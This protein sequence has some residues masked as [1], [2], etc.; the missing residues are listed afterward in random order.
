M[1]ATNLYYYR[2][3]TPWYIYPVRQARA[4]FL[5]EKKIAWNHLL[6]SKVEIHVLNPYL[7][8]ISEVRIR[9]YFDLTDK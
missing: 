8:N 1:L 2:Q 9:F 7:L 4:G 6:S 5:K 3:E